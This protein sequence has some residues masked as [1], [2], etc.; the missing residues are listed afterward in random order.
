[1]SLQDW[2][3]ANPRDAVAAFKAEGFETAV[4]REIA[5]IDTT[6]FQLHKGGEITVV[7][8]R[9]DSAKA[10]GEHLAEVDLVLEK[11][12]ARAKATRA[13]A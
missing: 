5:A 7:D 1:M 4:S 9:G 3:R 13:M 12:L 2:I 10:W 8:I 11:L 6:S